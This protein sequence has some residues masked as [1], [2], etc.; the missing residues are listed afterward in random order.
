MKLLKKLSKM[1]TITAQELHSKAYMGH[2][3]IIHNKLTMQ[4]KPITWRKLRDM[5]TGKRFTINSISTESGNAIC[6]VTPV[7]LPACK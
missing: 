2:K 5:P 6:N 3:V 4:D 1:N 7:F